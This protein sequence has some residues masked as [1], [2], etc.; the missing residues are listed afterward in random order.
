MEQKGERKE[1]KIGCSGVNN[2][3]KELGGKKWSP[4]LYWCNSSPAGL[5]LVGNMQSQAD[6]PQPAMEKTIVWTKIS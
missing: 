1:T 5:V 4:N 6:C 2:I 3:E